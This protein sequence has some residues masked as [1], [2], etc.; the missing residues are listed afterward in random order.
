MLCLISTISIAGWV[1]TKF[2]HQ[3][4]YVE[5]LTYKNNIITIFVCWDYY[6]FTVWIFKI[7]NYVFIF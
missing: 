4:L 6:I 5:V 3:S 2:V 7:W 1:N